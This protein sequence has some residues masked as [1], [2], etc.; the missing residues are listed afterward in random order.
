MSNRK[1]TSKLSAAASA[2][3][4]AGHAKLTPAQRSAKAR[5]AIAAR[6]ADRKLSETPA[7]V[8]QR[9]CRAKKKALPARS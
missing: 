7:A 1:P 9:R 5:T 2:M 4:S 3:A 8:A 6:W